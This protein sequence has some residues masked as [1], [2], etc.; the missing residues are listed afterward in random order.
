MCLSIDTGEKSHKANVARQGTVA[1]TVLKAQNGKHFF[2]I[3][4]F[5]LKWIR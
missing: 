1:P 4:N 5:K 2:I 3:L